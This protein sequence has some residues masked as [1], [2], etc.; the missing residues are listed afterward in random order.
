MDPKETEGMQDVQGSQVKREPEDFLDIRENTEM[1]G[2]MD[3]MG[4]RAFMDF[5]GKRE[6]KVIQVPRAAQV[7]EASLGDMG[8]RVSQGILVIQDKAVPSK[9]K[10]APKENKEDKVEPGR[11]GRK[12]VLA[13]EGAGEE[14]A[15]GES[16]VPW[17]NRAHLDLKVNQELKDCKDHREPVDLRAGKERREARD[18]K[19][20]RV[21]LDQWERK[22]VLEGLVLWGKRENLGFLE[23]QGQRGKWDS[24]ESRVTMASQAMVLW[25][26]KE[27][28]VH[29]DSLEI[30]AKRVILVILEFLGGLDP[31]DLGDSHSR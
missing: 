1:M 6:K 28:R 4:K 8:T 7:P 22:G 21:L 9:D 23:I 31:K 15:R 27:S 24:E 30:W 3:W 11:K 25:E 19:D 12:A 5:L 14:K 29:E 17:G 26:E 2:L 10:R 18:A 16:R 20:L 13:P